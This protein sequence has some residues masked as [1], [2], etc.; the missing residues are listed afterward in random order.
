LL[1]WA[2]SLKNQPYEFTNFFAEHQQQHQQHHTQP[3]KLGVID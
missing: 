3:L 2:N 1:D